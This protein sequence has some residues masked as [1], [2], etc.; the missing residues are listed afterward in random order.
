MRSMSFAG[1]QSNENTAPNSGTIA[2]CSAI[3]VL[4]ELRDREAKVALT[5][6]TELAQALGL[7]AGSA[8]NRA[9]RVGE[10][11]VAVVKQVALA[12]EK[13]IDVVDEIARDLLDPC[14][15]RLADHAV[16]VDAA[17]FEGSRVLRDQR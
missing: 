6:G 8:Q 16:G 10:Q 2:A 17:R 7:D 1:S 14:T 4:D 12:L 13:A 11:R 5:E 3:L 15:V 9:E